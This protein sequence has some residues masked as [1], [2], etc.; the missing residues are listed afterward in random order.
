[1]SPSSRPS[2][3]LLSKIAPSFQLVTFDHIIL[4]IS[5]IAFIA[6]YRYLVYLLV[7]MLKLTHSSP[8]QVS[9]QDEAQWLA[10]HQDL[11]IFVQ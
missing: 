9:P 6:I 4:P 5:S 10:F 7:Y 11:M 8:L 1:M 2:L 3:T